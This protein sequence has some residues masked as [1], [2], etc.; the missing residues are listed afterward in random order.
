[1][2]AKSDE[3]RNPAA[4]LTSGSGWASCW[5][6]GGPR[7]ACSVS[8][9]NA[10]SGS[11]TAACDAA[12]CVDGSERLNGRLSPSRVAAV[13]EDANGLTVG[14]GERSSANRSKG[15]LA[16]VLLAALSSSRPGMAGGGGRLVCG[17][18]VAS[19]VWCDV[20]QTSG[21]SPSVASLETF[22]EPSKVVHGESTGSGA[23]GTGKD[24]ASDGA[25]CGTRPGDVGL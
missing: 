4:W 8:C 22:H 18:Y 2:K 15:G 16:E 11:P 17:A 25:D 9:P 23:E 21:A 13:E 3:A 19:G 14:E 24:K 1:M 7:S 5:R 20:G 10:K 12:S 6:S